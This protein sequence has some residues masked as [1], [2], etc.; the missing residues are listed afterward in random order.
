MKEQVIANK[1]QFNWNVK[2]PLGS[3]ISYISIESENDADKNRVRYI[4]FHSPTVTNQESKC[5]HYNPS[6]KNTKDEMMD[7]V[8]LDVASYPNDTVLTEFKYTK[9]SSQIKYKFKC[10]KAFTVN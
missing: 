10:C 7:L 4:C 9:E 5:Q 3:A 6:G 1:G 8:S 2:C